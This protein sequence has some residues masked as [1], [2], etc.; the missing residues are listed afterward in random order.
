M[1][2]AITPLANLTLSAG[3][4]SVTFSSISGA[5]RDLILVVTG[6]S[7]SYSAFQIQFNGSATGYTWVGMEGNG[8]AN[9]AATSTSTAL[10]GN[11]N[12][13]VEDIGT[14]NTI[15]TMHLLDYAQTDK[16]KH[17]VYRIDAGNTGLGYYSGRWANTAAVTQ[18]VVARAAGNQWRT[19]STFALYGVSA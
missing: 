3:A 15:Y 14:S 18:V 16:H 1:P 19:G 10:E 17:A 8:S 7:G 4:T 9:A 13:W 6:G 12:Y 5:Y 11:Y 2:S